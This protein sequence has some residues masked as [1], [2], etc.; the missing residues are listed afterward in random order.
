MLNNFFHL[1]EDDYRRKK[2]QA[3]VLLYNSLMGISSDKDSDIFETQIAKTAEIFTYITDYKDRNILA[4]EIIL[5]LNIIIPHNI[6][7][8]QDFMNACQNILGT[9]DINKI[10]R[11]FRINTLNINKMDRKNTDI[12]ELNIIRQKWMKIKK[13][14]VEKYL[15]FNRNFPINKYAIIDYK[16]REILSYNHIYQVEIDI[17][18][19]QRL[20]KK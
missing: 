9:D 16:I 4:E 8:Y 5:G 14:L 13:L 18:D 17:Y 2:S 10:I 7:F 19:N 1:S 6:M 15:N 12:R 3:K 20:S 11:L